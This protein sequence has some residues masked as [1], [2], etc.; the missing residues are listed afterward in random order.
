M[1]CT[2]A[3][4]TVDP[5]LPFAALWPFESS[6]VP[7]SDVAAGADASARGVR[8]RTFFCLRPKALTLR[9]A[10]LDTRAVRL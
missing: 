3:A 9:P 7:L 10:N 2:T 4:S 5:L 1:A 6:L 8:H